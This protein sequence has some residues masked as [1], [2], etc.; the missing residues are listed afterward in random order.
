MS[1]FRLKNMLEY[2]YIIGKRGVIDA[3]ISKLNYFHRPYT[4]VITDIFTETTGDAF[5]KSY[6]GADYQDNLEKVNRR[7]SIFWTL[8]S[9]NL[10]KNIASD[11][12]SK[13]EKNLKIYFLSPI[14]RSPNIFSGTAARLSLP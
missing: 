11:I 14:I 5:L 4:G 1:E 10:F 9:S 8:T 3:V 2:R 7:M 13:A 12:N 6:Y